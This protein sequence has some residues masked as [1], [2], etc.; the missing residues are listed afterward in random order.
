MNANGMRFSSRQ[1]EVSTIS[2]SL[3]GLAKELDIPILALSQLNRGVE[4]RE[5]LEGKRPQLSDLRESGA[6]EQDA[7]MVLF[8]HRPEYYHILQ[9]EN[10]RDLRGM[11]QIIIAKHRK[12]ATGDVLLTF[13]GEFTRFE[14]PEDRRLNNKQTRSMGGEIVGSKINGGSVA[15]VVHD[16]T[17]PQYSDDGSQELPPF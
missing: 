10:G 2:R 8:V 11:A 4:S 16:D 7:D 3:K 12:G 15:P 13:R 14:N 5:G 17:F 1:E 6:I 9:D